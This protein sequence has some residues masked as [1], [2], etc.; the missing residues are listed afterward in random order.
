LEIVRQ[1]PEVTKLQEEIDDFIALGEAQRSAWLGTVSSLE[2][3]ISLAQKIN[4]SRGIYQKSQ[5]LIARWQLEIEDVSRLEKAR[6]LA[7]Q[8]NISDLSSAIN[9]AQQI[10]SNN[11][12]AKEAR[13]EVSHWRSQIETIEDQP[14]L[15][16][17]QQIAVLEDINSL[18]AAI[19]EASQ[20]HNGRALY[21][22]ARN[23]IRTWTAKIQQIQD[24]P[25]LDQARSLADNGD[26][27]NAIKTAQKIASSGRSLAPEAQ[28]SIDD[29][30]NQIR[31]KQNW[32]KA[33]TVAS[34]GTPEALVEAIRLANQVPQSS[35]VRSDATDG[36]D[37][38]SQQL[39]EIA[40]S[41]SQADV[42]RA[43]TIA[44]LIPRSSPS[45]QDAQA[46]IRDWRKALNPP[47]PPV[48]PVQSQPTTTA[49]PTS[50]VR[51]P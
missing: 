29:W 18:Q 47:A 8:G 13:Q 6:N 36:I 40:R 15:D 21:S 39:L 43:I 37:Q 46:Q 16:R 9:E 50:T 17:A 19:A 35:D 1:I 22:E 48:V 28:K 12:R 26:L 7:S 44:K 24:Q 2:E 14:Y 4:A 41:Q 23:K 20:I 3:A 30:Q 31:G 33:K 25:Y 5:N 49:S 11:P 10:P 27:G 45:Y 32:Q 42:T 34:A 38:W 51:Q